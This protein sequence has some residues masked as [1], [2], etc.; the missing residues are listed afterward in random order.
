MEL[1]TEK[2]TKRIIEKAWTD[3]AFKQALIADPVSAIEELTGEPLSI[4]EGKKVLVVVDQTDEE[5]YYFNIP[6]PPLEEVSEDF[7]LS[8][9]QLD[10]ISGGGD[11]TKPI[12]QG[13]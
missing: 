5:T 1:N 10:I 9:E 8:D 3:A 11:P 12:L 7:E 13:P 6:A 2:L 4:P